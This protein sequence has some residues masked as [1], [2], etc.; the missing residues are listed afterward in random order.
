[1]KTK[2]ITITL[3]LLAG[4][5]LTSCDTS[6]ASESSTPLGPDPVKVLEKQV[7]S[8]QQLRK[9]AEGRAEEASAVRDLWQLATLG[10]GLLTVVAF[11]GGTAI[12]SRG[13]HHHANA[14]S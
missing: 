3:I 12:G 5:M 11:F 7:Q 14:T 13:R 4:S 8:E 6:K 1:M 2:I 10:L 9:A